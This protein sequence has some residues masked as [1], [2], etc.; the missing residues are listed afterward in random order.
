M[1]QDW[2]A[3]PNYSHGLLVIPVV[4]FFLWRGRDS[5]RR[6]Q[7][8][9]SWSGILLFAVVALF[10]L[11]GTAAAENFS[12]RCAAVAG[13]GTLAWGLLGWRFVR[14]AWFPLVFLF[15]AV[16]WP[17]VIYYQVT[18]PLQLFSTKAACAMIDMFG[19]TFAR[20]GNII[21]LPG[22]SLEVVEACSGVRS[23]LSLATLGAAFAYLTQPGHVRPWILFVL[24]AP[25]ALLANV[26]RLVA[27]A[28]GAYAW[29]PEVAESL[30]H[31]LGG[32]L[33]FG[34]ALI[35]LMVTGSIISWTSRKRLPASP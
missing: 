17:Y 24:S 30:L 10:F 13:V 9:A 31:E 15:F 27:T 26:F 7:P 19:I 32:L 5:L 25:I 21:H 11:A 22:Y 16:P 35:A 29:G 8:I 4:L 6:V 1:A 18:F 14:A 34:A 3:D 33:V 12:V 23:L 28:L 20:Q 2:W